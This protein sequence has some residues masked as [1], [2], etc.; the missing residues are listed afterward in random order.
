MDE[1]VAAGAVLLLG[2]HERNSAVATLQ[3]RMQGVYG[4]G[5]GTLGGQPINGSDIEERMG[6]SRNPD[7]L[8]EMWTSWQNPPQ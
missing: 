5:K 8:K 4:K 2:V 1:P 3:A 7:E 6:T